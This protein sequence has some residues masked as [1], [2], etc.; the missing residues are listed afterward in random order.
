[1]ATRRWPFG[2]REKTEDEL[3]WFTLTIDYAARD[4]EEADRLAEQALDVI[5]RGE[6]GMG[7]HVCKRHDWVMT[8]GPI[9]D[10]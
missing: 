1:M 7:L 4:K 2:R 8:N 9:E 10:G 3:P 5:C 6:I